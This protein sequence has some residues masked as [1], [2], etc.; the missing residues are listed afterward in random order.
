MLPYNIKLKEP[1]RELRANM[2]FAEKRLWERISRRQIKGYRFC[3]QK[4]LGNY[5]VDFYCLKAKMVIEVDGGIHL[6]RENR[7]NDK[8]KNVYLKSL[9]LSVLRFTN[10]EVLINIEKV[11][12]KIKNKIPLCPP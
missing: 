7:E 5:I 10:D 2:T 11:V 6:S 12:N 3:R 1:S 4:P 8:N 9:N